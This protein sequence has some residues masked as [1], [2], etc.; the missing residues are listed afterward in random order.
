MF[1]I[2]DLIEVMHLHPYRL[3]L[4]NDANEDPD[5]LPEMFLDV[6]EFKGSDLYNKIASYEVTDLYAENTGAI[7]ICYECDIED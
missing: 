4:Q 2:G 1:T 3:I 6:E 7:W 5:Y